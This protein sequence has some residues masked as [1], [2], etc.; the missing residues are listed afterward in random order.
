MLIFWNFSGVPYVYCFHSFYLMKNPHFDLSTPVTVGLITILMI[1][2]YIW[3]TSQS[4][5]N[6]W[7]Q[8]V[9]GKYIKRYAFPQLPW[10]VL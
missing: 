2:Y 8:Q 10:G 5:K 7:R 4:Q 9:R 6:K 1:A 3:D